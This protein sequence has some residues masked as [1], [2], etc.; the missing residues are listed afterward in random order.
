MKVILTKD[1]PSV[2]KQG[3]VTNVAEGYARNFLFP[4][5][6]A[7][8]ASKA[9]LQNIER[10][11][12][13]EERMKEKRVAVAQEAA[14]KLTGKTFTINAKVGSG[15]K[16]FG[17]I[18]TGDIAEAVKAQSGIDLDKR[19]INLPKPI[20]TLGSHEVPVQLHRDVVAKL[21]LEVVAA[22]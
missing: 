12:A 19:K 13:L 5:K 8:E 11:H 1:V 22:E 20:K 10:Q 16:L 2:G 9:N 4:R 18:T 6:L 15:S 3:D 21:N 14:G 7:I 17:S